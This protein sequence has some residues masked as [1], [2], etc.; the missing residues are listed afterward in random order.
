MIIRGISGAPFV[1]ALDGSGTLCHESGYNIDPVSLQE[2]L[3][4]MT[5]SARNG[6]KLG[7][8]GDRSWE[9]MQLFK[10]QVVTVPPAQIDDLLPFTVAERGLYSVGPPGWF[11]DAFTDGRSMMW[12]VPSRAG[13]FQVLRERLVTACR[14]R[15]WSF[16]ETH[17]SA[18]TAR[19]RDLW[20]PDDDGLLVFIDNT[21]RS[22]FACQVRQ[23]R[24]HS[25]LSARR[26]GQAT[27]QVVEALSM[28]AT[29][30]FGDMPFELVSGGG[31][32]VITP[33]DARRKTA[34]TELRKRVPAHIPIF[35]FSGHESAGDC[36][37]ID[38]VYVITLK[39][40]VK[41]LKRAAW[42]VAERSLASGVA[43]GLW[44]LVHGEWP[45]PTR[46]SA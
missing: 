35:L 41:E 22:S 5:L 37:E 32:V 45:L 30:V 11:P 20:I 13:K 27:K 44:N 4:A 24:R 26:S 10:Q 8:M 16:L 39:N 2:L 28:L 15:N 42:K 36:A 23:V 1:A 12:H 29:E 33:A 6:A 25:M 18:F 21:R 7:L 31:R 40:A 3:R 38:G 19:N 9:G 46:Q 43:E 34:L 14:D 17:P